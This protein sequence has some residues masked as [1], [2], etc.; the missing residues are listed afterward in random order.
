MGSFFVASYNSQHYAG[1]FR[2]ASRWESDTGP[3][4]NDASNNFSIAACICVSRC[5]ATKTGYTYRHRDWW[6]EF[7]KHAT[8]R[9]SGV[10]TCIPSFV[11]IDSKVR[12]REEQTGAKIA[13][14]SNTRTFIFSKQGTWAKTQTDWNFSSSRITDMFRRSISSKDVY[15]S[16][17]W[18]GRWGD[19]PRFWFVFKLKTSSYLGLITS[20]HDWKIS[21]LN[22]AIEAKAKIR[23][24]PVHCK[25][26]TADFGRW[27]SVAQRSDSSRRS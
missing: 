24:F 20:Y 9:G 13:V 23:S 14:R 12:D 5:L 18:T 4:E 27:I 7:M 3:K 26:R 6:E 10:M 15:S 16:I 1:G 22:Q 19:G 11:K 21:Y 8:E 17:R 2:L 25:G